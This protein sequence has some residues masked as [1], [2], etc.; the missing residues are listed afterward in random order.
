[1]NTVRRTGPLI[2]TVSILQTSY[3]KKGVSVA[4]DYDVLDSITPSYPEVFL[5]DAMENLACFFDYA[6]NCYGAYGDEVSDLLSMSQLGEAFGAGDPHY[7]CG[8][9]G[10][11][12]FY[13]LNRSHG[14]PNDR[15]PAPFPRFERTPE[16][17]VGWAAA[18]VQ[19]RLGIT[20]AQ[21]FEVL[22]YKQFNELYGVAH[23]APEEW[24]ALRVASWMQRAGSCTRLAEA[25]RRL[26]ISQR[27]LAH[28][29]G[30]SLRSIQMYEQRNKDINKAHAG[31][32]AA[33]AKALHVTMEDLP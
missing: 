5:N 17:W 32:L 15:L 31:S 29:S 23:E 28:R 8:M 30:V 27:E 6:I 18:Y 33:L 25:R 21:L 13:E 3:V 12:M 22:P 14:Y 20:L 2:E 19:W 7:L 16:Y 11:E 4:S 9:S 24:L 1:M 10:I 26:G